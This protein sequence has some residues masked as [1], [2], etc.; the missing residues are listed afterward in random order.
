MKNLRN[1]HDEINNNSLSLTLF[2]CI[3]RLKI[4]LKSY[5]WHFKA[6]LTSNRAATAVEFALV[7]P[8]FILVVA[9]IIVFGIY[10]GMAHSVQQLAADAA[11]ASVAGL[12][13]DERTTLAR[14]EVTNSIA[15]YAFLIPEKISVIAASN[16]VDANLFE[17]RVNYDASSSPIWAFSGIMPVMPPVQIERAAI[18]RRGGY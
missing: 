8:I 14:L 7:A 10:F 5:P 17:V 18:I 3:K 12:S 16:P 11:R 15:S 6:F 4:Q 1:K 13:T 2:I 9:G